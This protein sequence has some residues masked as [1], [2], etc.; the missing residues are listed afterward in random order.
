MMAV[1]SNVMWCAVL[2]AALSALVC[3][4]NW[5]VE[6]GNFVVEVTGNEN[7]PKVHT[8]RS[9]KELKAGCVRG[10]ARANLVGCQFTPTCSTP[11]T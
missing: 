7:V 9:A 3:G 11:F 4:E 6:S 10:R 1:S 5:T 2:L 8:S